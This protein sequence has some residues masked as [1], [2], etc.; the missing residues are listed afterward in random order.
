MATPLTSKINHLPNS[1]QF[2]EFIDSFNLG[3]LYYKEQLILHNECFICK[4]YT[5]YGY[6]FMDI[7]NI[8]STRFAEAGNFIDYKD[9]KIKEL[10]ERID[11]QNYENIIDNEDALKRFY[12]YF[13]VITKFFPDIFDCQ[14]NNKYAEVFQPFSLARY[15]TWKILAAIKKQSDKQSK[16][17][18]LT[19]Q[20]F[21]KNFGFS[22]GVRHG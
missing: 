20:W 9:E 2:K 22:D 8:S 14:V 15:E 3:Y 16:P 6:P 7:Y 12:F 4:L 17:E 18:E 1:S 5:E 19:D 10:K 11:N 21:V 13:E